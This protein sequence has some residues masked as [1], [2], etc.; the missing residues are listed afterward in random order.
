ML[1]ATLKYFGGKASNLFKMEEKGISIPKTWVISNNYPLFLY[2][3]YNIDSNDIKSV[4]EFL[5]NLPRKVYKEIFEEVSGFI[6]NNREI[7]RFAVRSSQTYEDGKENSFSGLFYTGLNISKPGEM[8]DE[9]IRCWKESYNEGV[10]EYSKRVSEFKIVPCSV[11]IQQFIQS[12]KSGVSF[13]WNDRIII[14]SNYGLAKAI[15]DGETGCDELIIN[16][17]NKEIISYTTNKSYAIIP[18]NSRVNPNLGENVKYSNLIN[19]EVAEFDNTTSILKVKLNEETK[20]N[21][22]LDE[23]EINELLNTC[24]K[25][26]QELCIENYDI[27]WTFSGEKLYILQC[28]PLTKPISVKKINLGTG[29]GLGLVSGE[30]TGVAL[31]IENEKDLEK[32]TTNNFILITNKLYGGTILAANKASGCI[33]QSKSPLSHSAIIAREIGIPVVGAV[34]LNEIIEGEIYYI[35]GET[36]DY[37][38]IDK[39]EENTEKIIQNKNIDRVKI[40][41]FDEYFDFS[42]S[43]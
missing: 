10:I 14:D 22:V 38:I 5:E 37:K 23:N 33:L 3:E 11:I 16:N 19:L 12:E 8:V 24:E 27:E 40:S 42:I 6:K 26:A 2:K 1:V 32:I 13:R 30:A 35:N 34:D 18:I 43:M 4:Q 28:R 29:L 7:K 21:K 36:G 9:I 15:V 25:V 31:K 20:N 17:S 39:I 41:D